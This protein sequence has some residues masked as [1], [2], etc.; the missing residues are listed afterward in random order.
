MAL[1][2]ITGQIKAKALDLGFTACGIAPA[3][4][5]S[6][7]WERY[8]SILAKGNYIPFAYLEKYRQVR[9]DPRLIKEWTRSVIGLLMN[10]YPP[11]I[12]EEEDNYI[13]SKYAYGKSYRNLIQ[14]RM[15]KLVRFMETLPGNCRAK[16]FVDSGPVMEKSWAQRCGLGWIG[17]NTLVI[18]K[19]AGSYFFIGMILTDLDLDPD[20]PETDHCGSC[21]RC[22]KACPTNALSTP[23]ELDPLR[24]ISY[25]TI[26]NKSEMP[27]E[28]AGKLSRRIYGCDICQDA[29]PY[30]G[31]ASPHNEPEFL[32]S[33]T[34]KNLR[35]K[36][37]EKMTEE[38]FRLLFTGTPVKRAGYQKL[39]DSVSLAGK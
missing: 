33:E 35:R 12:L 29:C 39:M 24:C 17:K 19:N 16:A 8:D 4:T 14:A 34:L 5:L 9:K 26:V 7:E 20:P 11:E 23:Y 15:E 21:D 32:P 18:R 6:P 38:E 37:W 3:G 30:N 13:V 31:F 36:E 2:S 27:A 10:Y 25:Q 22:V 1:P 28:I